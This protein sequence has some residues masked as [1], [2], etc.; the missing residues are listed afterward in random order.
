MKMLPEITAGVTPEMIA[1]A[2]PEEEIGEGEELIGQLGEDL[3]KLHAL[4]F[5][6]FKKAKKG[7]E[8]LHNTAKGSAEE[9]EAFQEFS[10]L[11]KSADALKGISFLLIT[12]NFGLNRPHNSDGLGVRKGWQVVALPELQ[13]LHLIIPICIGI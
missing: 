11:D 10:F 1:E 6:S 13:H 3:K 9:T 5:H 4:L 7:Y 8:R 12:A 2:E